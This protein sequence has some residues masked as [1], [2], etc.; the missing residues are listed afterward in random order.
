MPVALSAD[1]V[2]PT[3]LYLLELAVSLIPSAFYGDIKALYPSGEYL[4]LRPSIAAS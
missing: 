3:Q 1:A 4:Q 2:N